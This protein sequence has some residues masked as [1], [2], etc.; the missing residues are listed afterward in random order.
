MARC[1][2]LELLQDRFE[3]FAGLVLKN[4][5]MPVRGRGAFCTASLPG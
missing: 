5:S 1:V 3:R 4:G 2:L